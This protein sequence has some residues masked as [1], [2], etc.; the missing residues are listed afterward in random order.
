MQIAD[1]FASFS[2]KID[3][4]SVKKADATLDRI[5]A[6][7]NGMGSGSGFR[8][9]KFSINQGKLDAT[10]AKAL[11]AASLKAV[12]NITKF[13]VNQTALNIA[14][15]NALDLASARNTF[16]IAR[17]NVD[18]SHLNAQMVS[19]MANAARIASAATTL[20]PHFANQHIQPTGE[21]GLSHRSAALT[22]GIAG[23]LSRLYAPALGLALGGYGLSQLNQRNQQVVS[24]QL[25]SQAVVQQAGGS[26][27]EGS[28]S[29]QYLRSE[30]QRIGFNYLDASGD[31]NKLI[32]GLTGSGVGLKESQKVFS[33]FAELARVNKLDKTTQNRLFRALS[34]VAGKGKLQS[35]ELT[36]QIAEALPGGTALFAQA[37]QAKIGGN[38]TG[39]EAIQQLLAD[40]KKGKVTSDIL[41]YA[42]A[43][44]SQRANEGGAL[45][46]ASTASQA[47]QA[48]YQNSVNDLAVVASNSGVEE[49]FARIFRTL[50]AGLSESNDLVK[51]LSEGFNDATKWAD[52]LLLWPQS[53]IRALEGK[54]SIVADWLGVGQTAQLQEDWKQIKQIF[55]DIS[56]L[57]FDFLPTLQATSKEIAAILGAIAE[58]EKW[59]NG[60]KDTT[61]P[62]ELQY[63]SDTEKASLFGFEYTS[64]AAIVS[65]IYNNAGVG[66]NKARIRGRAV[67]ED[68]T[69]PFYQN[70]EKFDADRETN[71]LYY[72]NLTA[73]KAD[74]GGMNLGSAVQ[75]AIDN[76]TLQSKLN[77]VLSSR[78]ILSDTFKNQGYG[79]DNQNPMMSTLGL[80]NNYKDLQI[81]PTVI[82]SEKSLY[83]ENYNDLTTPSGEPFQDLSQYN[84]STPDEIAD[85]NKSAAMAAADQNV[86]NNSTQSNQFDIQISIDGATL[87]GMDVAGQ[88]Q[89][90][91]DAFTAQVTAAFEHAQVQ[92]PTRE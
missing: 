38:K 5:E 1:Y 21:R 25:Q 67:Y 37:Y 74:A 92:Y 83:S 70:P 81:D 64:P 41:T 51:T 56:S 33:G 79:L 50:N 75:D 18:Q 76:D 24:A 58:F 46:K 80:F 4:A 65:D 45:G 34:Q 31:Y 53:F 10:L 36:G 27:Q 91:A 28:N 42:G 61:A 17:F 85:M 35:E 55:I 22:G 16:Q 47:E 3:K 7:L 84:S 26:L 89:A 14:L 9:G 73:I 86:T 87:M 77:N 62:K 82:N 20:R 63:K 11:D 44:A 15:G 68:P 52:D 13:D 19:A 59:K 6:R 69:S 39:S 40:M 78:D 71:A 2:L 54:D 32:S 23:G 12:F 88:G 72:Q 66:L 49:G 48:R 30:G 29:F 60:S 57:K 43:A 90:L 8:L